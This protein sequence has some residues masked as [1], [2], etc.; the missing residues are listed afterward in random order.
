M[1]PQQNPPDDESSR[2]KNPWWKPA[3]PELKVLTRFYAILGAFSLVLTLVQLFE[4]QAAAALAWSIGLMI[5]VPTLMILVYRAVTRRIEV[6]VAVMIAAVIVTV[7]AGAGIGGII[8]YTTDNPRANPPHSEPL[9]R[10]TA[11]TQ[12]PSNPPPSIP[13]PRQSPS[14]PPVTSGASGS[15]TSPAA[16]TGISDGYLSASGIAR[17]LPRGYRLDLFLKVTY[18]SVYYSAGDPNSQLTITG[19]KWSGQIFIGS[20]GPTAV[21][22]YLVEL[23]PASVQLVNREYTYQSAGYPSV[24]ALGTV[25]AKVQLNLS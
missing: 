18:L 7:L 13:S 5:A 9:T 14:S 19:D 21:Y 1:T 17:N 22:I 16:S 20:Q 25:L 11:D 23:S 3:S 8:R 4:H 10:A 6:R 12:Q 15:F 24:T 2:K